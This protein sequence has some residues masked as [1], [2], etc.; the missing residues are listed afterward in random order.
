MSD[1]L[2]DDTYTKLAR[3]FCLYQYHKRNGK[4]KSELL[5]IGISIN[6]TIE[7]LIDTILEEWETL[8]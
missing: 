6:E 5:N 7:D 4:T 3:I 8:E 1:E 2:K